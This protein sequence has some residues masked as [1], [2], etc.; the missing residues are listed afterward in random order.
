ME[1]SPRRYC[2]RKYLP[3]EQKAALGIAKQKLVQLFGP[4]DAMD[5]LVRGAA[6]CADR[7]LLLHWTCITLEARRD[8]LLYRV[9]LPLVSRGPRLYKGAWAN[10]L[11]RQI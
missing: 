5:W 11:F 4:N 6:N 1:F 7:K 8:A 3:F 10:R 2:G 9:G